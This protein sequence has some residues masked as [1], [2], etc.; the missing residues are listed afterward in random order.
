MPKLSN[1]FFLKG[2]SQYSTVV[3]GMKAKVK[4][5]RFILLCV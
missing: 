2:I 4:L 5:T 1:F 3:K